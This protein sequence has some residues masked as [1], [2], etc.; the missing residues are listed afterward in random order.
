MVPLLA[1][2]FLPGWLWFVP[3]LGWLAASLISFDATQTEG[4]AKA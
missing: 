2:D 4:Q 1:F 3:P